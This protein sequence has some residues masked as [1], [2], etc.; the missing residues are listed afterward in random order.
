[1]ENK[2]VPINCN[3]MVSLEQ[4]HAKTFHQRWGPYKGENLP[5]VR[6]R[7]CP[8]EI[9]PGPSKVESTTGYEIWDNLNFPMLN[10]HW[11]LCKY[12]P[13]LYH[14]I[15]LSIPNANQYR[16]MAIKIVL[17]IQINK[18]CWLITDRQWSIL[19]WLFWSTLIGIG[20]W[21]RQSWM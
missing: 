11:Q 13:H 17:S 16:S 1:M 18:D 12:G 4:H 9:L 5:K 15:T 20:Q 6:S 10:P 8:Y 2:H 19:I 7:Y 3:W 21:S 14:R